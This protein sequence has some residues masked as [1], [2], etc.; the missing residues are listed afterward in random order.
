M[1]KILKLFENIS[2]GIFVNSSYNWLHGDNS[3]INY[4]II[5]GS[6]YAM[7]IAIIYQED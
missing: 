2:L 6:I 4:Y 5:A 3:Q 1:N 7:Y